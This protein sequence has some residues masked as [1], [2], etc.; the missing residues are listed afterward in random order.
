MMVDLRIAEFG[1]SFGRHLMF[2]GG[3]SRLEHFQRVFA[4]VRRG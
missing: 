3:H 2:S 4:A 1:Q